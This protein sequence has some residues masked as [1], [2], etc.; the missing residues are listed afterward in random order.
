MVTRINN[1]INDPIN[2]PSSEFANDPGPFQLSAR[3][4]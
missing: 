4:D 3:T 1:P 2:N